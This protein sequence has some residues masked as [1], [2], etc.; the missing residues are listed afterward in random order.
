MFWS[1]FA[2]KGKEMGR[3][4]RYRVAYSGL[5]GL[6]GL[7]FGKLGW[8]LCEEEKVGWVLILP[9]WAG[10]LGFFKIKIHWAGKKERSPKMDRFE[11]G[12]REG[13]CEWEPEI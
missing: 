8:I 11:L 4:N 2:E 10:I 6:P 9:W 12:K 3:F 5:D 7:V 1:S 13:H